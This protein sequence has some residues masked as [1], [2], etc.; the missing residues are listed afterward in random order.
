MTAQLA[1]PLAIPRVNGR[2]QDKSL[3]RARRQRA[4]ELRMTGMTYQAI[5]DEMG[6]KNPGSVYT[7][8]KQA[9]T[10]HLGSVTEDYRTTELARL[11]ALQAALWPAAMRGRVSAVGA[12]LR[13]IQARGRLL[14]LY[15][16]VRTDSKGQNGWDNCQGPPTVVINPRDCRWAGCAKHGAFFPPATTV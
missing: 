15:D 4:I 13:I 11:D 6:Y 5:A 2:H 14:G 1:E 8:I 9:Q 10:Q 12:V 7:I 16:S 3:A